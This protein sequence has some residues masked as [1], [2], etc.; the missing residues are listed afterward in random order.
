MKEVSD[1]LFK[2]YWALLDSD[3]KE[4]RKLA[5]K[6]KLKHEIYGCDNIT[7]VVFK[8]TGEYYIKFLK[9]TCN[10]VEIFVS[11]PSVN[12]WNTTLE[13]IVFM[14]NQIYEG[15]DSCRQKEH[16]KFKNKILVLL[17][18]DGEEAVVAASKLYH[19]PVK[20]VRWTDAE[21]VRKYIKR[22]YKYIV[23]PS[24]TSNLIALKDILEDYPNV[25]FISPL[26]TSNLPYSRA[27]LIKLNLV[28]YQFSNALSKI[29]S[30]P[31]L[32]FSDGAIPSN[33]LANNITA[34]IPGSITVQLNSSIGYL[35]QTEAALALYPN[36]GNIFFAFTNLTQAYFD[37]LANSTILNG[38]V[39]YSSDTL[40]LFP[41]VTQYQIVSLR[42]LYQQTFM[43][44]LVPGGYYQYFYADACYYQHQ[45][46][47]QGYR[48]L[49]S[50]TGV[51]ELDRFGNR[52]YKNIT[53]MTFEDG[54]WSDSGII[55][56]DK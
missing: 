20:I 39:L 10:T 14:Y 27:N 54:S 22:G 47:L 55:T 34:D 9:T 23:G 38:K 41:L 51:I 7:S 44:A 45:V 3:Y 15:Y 37:A 5:C 2:I 28:N 50:L 6:T 18:Y 33:E 56:I 16:C 19:I 43:Q 30:Q 53:I 29:V 24:Y 17:D 1:I 13:N 32:I 52:L 36:I 26:A 35:Q 40:Q 25:G 31:M 21:D 46:M 12:L 4:V 11:D 49:G 8:K 48:D 42:P